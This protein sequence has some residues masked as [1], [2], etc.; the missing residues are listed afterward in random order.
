M[1]GRAH[2]LTRSFDF[3]PFYTRLGF[4][5]SVCEIGLKGKLKE[6]IKFVW[7]EQTQ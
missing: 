6:G 5:V 7:E 4:L 2:L 3:L 1:F